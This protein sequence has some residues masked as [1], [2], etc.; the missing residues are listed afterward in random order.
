MAEEKKV[1]LDVPK[2]AR[3]NWITHLRSRRS[4]WVL[5]GKLGRL[6][7]GQV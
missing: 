6:K 1:R 4:S 2:E 7:L 5:G 3:V